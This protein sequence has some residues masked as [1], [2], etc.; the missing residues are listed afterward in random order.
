MICL[1][2]VKWSIRVCPPHNGAWFCQES[3]LWLAS[4]CSAKVCRMSSFWYLELPANCPSYQKY[5][6]TML[7]MCFTHVTIWMEN[8]FF[9]YFL[10]EIQ[11]STLYLG[12]DPQG[13]RTTNND[14]FLAFT[15]IF[16][17]F[18]GIVQNSW[19][20]FAWILIEICEIVD[21]SYEIGL[22]G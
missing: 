19:D 5:D 17:F 12:L 11:K 22:L 7:K 8:A 16:F 15:S 14:Q 10:V 20:W 3:S 6:V 4:G 18:R 2:V 21:N 9:P 13:Y 1:R